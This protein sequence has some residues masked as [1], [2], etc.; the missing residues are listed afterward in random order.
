[1]TATRQRRQPPLDVVALLVEI[2]R[3]TTPLHGAACQGKHQLFD[4]DVRAADL[5]YPNEGTRWDEVRR[6][7]TGC[8]VR[9][10]CWAWASNQKQGR[11]SGPTAATQVNPINMR[12]NRIGG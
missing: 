11:V 4:L 2:V 6:T 7:C 12:R 5:G 8:P 3:T 9:G 10:Q 1:M